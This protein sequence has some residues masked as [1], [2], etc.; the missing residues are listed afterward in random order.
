MVMILLRARSWREKFDLLTL[1]AEMVPVD[2]PVRAG[3]LLAAIAT[4]ST[5][6]FRN[7]Y[8]HV[9]NQVP[10]VLIICTCWSAASLS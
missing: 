9:Y 4:G 2:E 5:L 6:C 7:K 8:A 3:F 10:T 1:A